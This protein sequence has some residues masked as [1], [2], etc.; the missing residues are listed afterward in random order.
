MTSKPEPDRPPAGDDG[1][2]Q[3]LEGTYLEGAL[4]NTSETGAVGPIP[5]RLHTVTPRLVVR[6]GVAAID[7]YRRAFGAQELGDRFT[8]PD[9]ELILPRS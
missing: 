4:V 3:W 9:G 2:F 1:D 8:G 5:D 7:F 6:D